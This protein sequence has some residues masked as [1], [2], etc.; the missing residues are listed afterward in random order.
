[1]LR[2]GRQTQQAV[3]RALIINQGPGPA[4]PASGHRVTDR[5]KAAGA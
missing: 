5:L 4:H 2:T 3:D 1:M